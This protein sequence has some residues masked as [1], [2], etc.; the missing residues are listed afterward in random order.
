MDD[1]LILNSVKEN[2]TPQYLYDF[3]AIQNRIT[4]VKSLLPSSVRLYYAVKANPNLKL[5][6]YLKPLIDGLDISS[7]G[8]IKQS[9]QA[10]YKTN[11]MNFAGPG[12][13]KE[14]LEFAVKNKIGSLSIESSSDLVRLDLVASKLKQKANVLVRI[15]PSK[16]VNKFAMKMGGKA[17]QFG[18]DEEDLDTVINVVK[19]SD[20]LGFLGFHVYSGTQCLDAQALLENYAYTLDL[21]E[22]LIGK[23]DLSIKKIDLGGGF[24]IPYFA[25]EHPLVFAGFKAELSKLLANFEKMSGQKPEYILEL[26]RYLVAEAGHYVTKLINQKHSKGTTYYILDGGMHHNLAAAGYLGQVIRKN[27][28][29]RNLSRNPGKTVKVN[30]AGTLCT[31]LDTMATNLEVPESEIGDII[32]FYNSGAYAFSASPLLFLSHETPPEVL[33]KDGA[34]E[35]IRRSFAPTDFNG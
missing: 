4:E 21:V 29:V 6:G 11:S 28:K 9:I 27:Y 5:L 15:N 1:K 19:K 13:T 23:H 16:L 24:G 33:Y 14:E 35:L 32:V 17:T 34:Y 7:G 18:V 26:G 25:G 22:K 3:P 31:P 12:K 8:E 20:N 30:L 10:G 2:G